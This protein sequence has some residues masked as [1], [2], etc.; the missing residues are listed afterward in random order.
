MFHDFLATHKLTIQLFQDWFKKHSVYLL[1]NARCT[2]DSLG[3]HSSRIFDPTICPCASSNSTNWRIRSLLPAHHRFPARAPRHPILPRK[4]RST[5][6]SSLSSSELASGLASD[7]A[8]GKASDLASDSA[9]DLA[10]GTASDLASDLAS[11]MAW[12]R[13]LGLAL[14]A[15][16]ATAR[17]LVLGRGWARLVRNN[18]SIPT[19]NFHWL[20][21]QHRILPSTSRSHL[22]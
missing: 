3:K 7:L 19:C 16:W 14:G 4:P 20:V 11:G 18:S 10:W 8:S 13:G 22:H 1:T 2:L 17:A 15:A 21:P 12:A 5:K 9:S 6:S